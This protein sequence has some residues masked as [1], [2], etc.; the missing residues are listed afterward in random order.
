MVWKGLDEEELLLYDEDGCKLELLDEKDVAV[1]DV[2]VEDVAVEDV[3]VEDE[4]NLLLDED[5]DEDEDD[6]LGTPYDGLA[7]L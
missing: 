3:V 6:G 5:E 1:E 7:E 2:A 4:L